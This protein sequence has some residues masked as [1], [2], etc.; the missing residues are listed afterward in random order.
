M[1]HLVSFIPVFWHSVQNK[2]NYCHFHKKHYNA[3]ILMRKPEVQITCGLVITSYGN[4]MKKLRI[5]PLGHLVK[6]FRIQG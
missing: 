2:S 4:E 3:K 5:V 6:A 1:S